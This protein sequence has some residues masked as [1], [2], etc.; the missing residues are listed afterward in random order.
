M[1][2]L[3]FCLDF[4][5]LP[6][7]Q[8]DFHPSRRVLS[9]K[10]PLLITDVEKMML[11]QNVFVQNDEDIVDQLRVLFDHLAES[12]VNAGKLVQRVLFLTSGVDIREV[13]N[14]V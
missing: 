6:G 5:I 4:I 1:S 7:I 2:L 3:E 11:T 13:G 8:S 10:V 14:D 12:A 9:N